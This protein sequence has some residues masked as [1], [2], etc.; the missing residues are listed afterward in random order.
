MFVEVADDEAQEVVEGVFGVRW[1]EAGFPLVHD[2]VVEW[3]ELVEDLVDLGVVGDLVGDGDEVCGDEGPFKVKGEPFP[4]GFE[5]L[6][7]DVSGE[8]DVIWAASIEPV[9]DLGVVDTKVSCGIQVGTA[10]FEEVQGLE[11]EGALVES[12]GVLFTLFEEWSKKIGLETRR[13]IIGGTEPVVFVMELAD[14]CVSLGFGEHTVEFVVEAGLAG[15]LGPGG[16]FLAGDTEFL[17]DA[18]AVAAFEVGFAFEE[19]DEGEV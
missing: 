6:W 2:V 14:E 3:G 5:L 13:D 19:L 7:G 10:V 12:F 1:A 11:V 8:F 9:H 4:V 16:E 18:F 15:V 17:T